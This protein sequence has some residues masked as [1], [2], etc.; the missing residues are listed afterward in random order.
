VLILRGV[1]AILDLGE[2]FWKRGSQHAPP[3]TAKSRAGGGCGRE[4]PP[5]ALGSGG[6]IRGKILKF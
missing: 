2:R 4:S 6:I 5:P 3:R 1:V